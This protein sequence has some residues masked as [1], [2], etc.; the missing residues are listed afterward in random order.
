[1]SVFNKK[2]QAI[3]WVIRN[4][5][6]QDPEQHQADFQAWLA[7]DPCHPALYEAQRHRWEK[8]IDRLRASALLNPNHSAEEIIETEKARMAY[9]RRKTRRVAALCVV[10]VTVIGAWVHGGPGLVHTYSWVTYQ[11]ETEQTSSVPLRDGS[12]VLLRIHSQV[13]VQLTNLS[14]QLVLDYGE[15]FFDINSDASGTFDVEVGTATVQAMDTAFSVKKD[16]DGRI[17]VAVKRGVLVVKLAESPGSRSAA[18]STP[19]E[20]K[21]GEVVTID[22]DGI[23][24]RS[25]VGRAELAD[26]LC[27][28]NPSYSFI[29]MTLKDAVELF[30]R[31]NARKLE[32]MGGGLDQI[33]V[34]G[35]FRL[36]EPEKFVEA[37]E[38]L[39]VGHVSQG[40]ESHANSPILLR[41]MCPATLCGAENDRA[42]PL[43]TSKS[44]ET[45]L[46]HQPPAVALK[47]NP[48]RFSVPNSARD[49]CD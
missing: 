38:Y 44:L 20:I 39:G 30:N 41:K 27:W 6:A 19:Q 21:A 33:V 5:T 9:V 34:D 49:Y 12:V 26:R 16:N 8:G 25:I 35:K 2:A 24:S 48:L 40:T 3:Q 18:Q 23:L 17:E 4:L 42:A 29:R 45:L 15:A 10:G 43:L 32:M 14:R 1:M 46:E 28:A 47:I 22:P 36:T 37:L 11:L 13:R 7:R 31:Y